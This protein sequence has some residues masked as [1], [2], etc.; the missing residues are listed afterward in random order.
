MVLG[1]GRRR[2]YLVVGAGVGVA[3]VLHG[4]WF[5]MADIAPKGEHWW[6]L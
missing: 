6:W 2:W 5:A 3:L 4:V 1:P